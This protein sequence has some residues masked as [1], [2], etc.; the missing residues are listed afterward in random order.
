MEI[1]WP[2]HEILVLISSSSGGP[3]FLVNA[4]YGRGGRPRRK[5]TFP[6]SLLIV[7]KNGDNHIQNFHLGRYIVGY[8]FG[9]HVL[10]PR[11]RVVYPTIYLLK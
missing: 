2:S 1:F 9:N 11:L 3:A 8:T 6:L 5:I 7:H 4:K 10:R